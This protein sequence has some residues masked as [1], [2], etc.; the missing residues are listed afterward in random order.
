MANKKFWLGL[1]ITALVVGTVVIGCDNAANAGSA[2]SGITYT[3]TADGERDVVTSTQLTFAF[4]A[5]VSG[6]QAADI[7]ITNGTGEASKGTLTGGGASWKLNITDIEPGTVKVKIAKAGIES[8]EKEVTVHKVDTPDITYI[9]TANG[10]ADTVTSSQLTFTFSAAV[11]GLRLE[12]IIITNGTG[13]AEKDGRAINGTLTGSDTIWTLHITKVTAG[14]VKVK[15]DKDGIESTEKEVTVHKDSAT[16][17]DRS[18]AITLTSGLWEN[19]SLA[20]GEHELWYKFE[21][22]AGKEYRVHLKSDAY[23]GVTAYKEGSTTPIE[24]FNEVIPY[25]PIPISGVSGTVY[26]KVKLIVTALGYFKGPFDIRFF[27]PENMGPQDIIEIYEA[28]A[29]LNF[30]V[31][32][33]WYVRAAEETIESSGYRVYRSDTEDGTYEKIDEIEDSSI[34]NYI[35]KNLKAGKTYWYRVAGYNSK[36]GGEWSEPKQS[37]FVADIE[38]GTVLTIGAEITKGDLKESMQADWYKFTAEAGRTYTVQSETSANREHSG[39]TAYLVN[40]SALKSDKTPI[41]LSLDYDTD[42]TGTISGVSGTVYLKVWVLN[43]FTGTYGIKVSQ[44]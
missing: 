24:D 38:A 35:D 25:D 7:T 5:E 23:L 16:G 33:K 30:S 28:K 42:Y 11:S 36:G 22:A 8:K 31:V 19:G 43:D 2:E 17:E 13:A 27:D 44:K 9:V 40:V 3:V 26:L 32:I 10:T 14:T 12:N 29:T 41:D 39:Y 37:E 15:I 4:N 20:D 21:A 34:C 6:L 18:K 1:L